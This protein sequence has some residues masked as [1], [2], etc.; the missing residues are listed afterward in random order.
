[1]TRSMFAVLLIHLLVYCSYGEADDNKPEQIHVGFTGISSERIVNYVTPS[2]TLKPETIV[3]YGTSPNTLNKKVTGDSFVFGTGGH[4]FTIHN[5]K[6]T[7]LEPNTRYY[8]QVGVPDNGTSEVM[9]FQTKDGN[10]V[11][12][13]YGDM[14][15]TNSVSLNRLIQEV[16]S[17]GYDTVIHVGDMAYDMYEKDGDTGDNFMRSIQPI[18][19]K[20]P[21]MVLPGNHEYKYNFTHYL[22]RFSNMELGVGQTSGSETSLWWSLDIGLIHFVGFDTEVYY[23]YSDKGQIQRQLNWLEADLI[24]ANQNRDKTP[25]IVSLAHKAWFMEKTDFSDFGPLMHK[26]GVDLHLCGHAHNYQ[27]LY[28]TYGGKLDNQTKEHVYINPAYLTTIVAGSAGSKEKL[29][30]GSAPKKDLA[31]Y[32]EDYGYGHL[33]AINRT[34]LYW[35]WENTHENV[36]SV[37]QDYLWIVQEHHGMRGLYQEKYELPNEEDIQI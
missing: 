3:A 11:F 12:A 4:N 35:T 16:N 26:Y 24:K 15:Y 21:Y 14:G 25:W 22:H 28:P 23:Y 20:V 36:R 30:S 32:I 34:H 29:S 1:M 18:A 37:M 7:G 8:Y 5:V 17:G 33:Q 31:K 27:R 13:V 19:T 2:P 6:L 9:S 10:L